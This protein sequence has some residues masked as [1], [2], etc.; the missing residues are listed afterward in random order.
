MSRAQRWLAV[1]VVSCLVLLGVPAS[2]WSA[3]PDRVS[4]A[5]AAAAK[6]FEVP[7]ALLTAICYLEGRFGDHGGA[8]SVDGGYGCMHLVRNDH[9]DSLDRAARLLDMPVVRVQT[10]LAVNIAGG[11]AVLRDEARRQGLAPR[12]LADW[13]APLAAYSQARTRG[14]ATGYADAVYQLLASGVSGRAQSGEMIRLAPVNVRPD[15]SAIARLPQVAALPAGCTT[16]TNVD[17]PGAVNCIVPTSYDCNT[18]SPCTYAGAN[19]PTDLP[20]RF[21]T[22]HDIEG[23]ATDAINVFWDRNS[24]VSMQYIVD[25]DGT[26]YQTLREKDIPYQA[27]NYWYNERAVGIEH[28]GYDA[29]GYQWY[30]ATEYLGSAKLVAYLLTKY[31]IPLDH[32]HVMSHGTT[33][34]PTLGSSPNHV[35]PGPYWLWNYYLGLINQQGVPFPSGTSPAGVFTLKPAS[36]QQPLGP[37]GTETQDN[38]NFFYLYTGPSTAYPKVP[39]KGSATDITDVTDNV[40]PAVSYYSSQHVTDPA[41]SGNEMYQIWYGETTSSTS[42]SAT[43]TQA[44]LAVPPGAAVPG[45]GSVVTLDTTKGKAVSVY[46]RPTASRSYVIGDSPKGSQYVAP[47]TTVEAGVLW[48]CINFNHRQAWVPASSVTAVQTG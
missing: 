41:G 17:Y 31:G 23:T 6:R 48:Y 47:Y 43:G 14:V 20:I 15:R 5:I 27:G 35:D 38:F 29:T 39:R 33:P 19:R 26:V 30:N 44:W 8:P 24:Q 32:D 21:V 4:A 40:E 45:R 37:N 28:T 16:D 13:Y 12:G 7:A 10:D 9:G 1:A 25:T 18:S 22:V 46:G 11:A 2:A 36:D 34:S 3:P 42:Y